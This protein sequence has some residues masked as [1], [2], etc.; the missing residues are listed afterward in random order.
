MASAGSYGLSG[1]SGP[2][3]YWLKVAG[4]NC[5]GPSAPAEFAPLCTPGRSD[6]P[7]SVS[8]SPIPASTDQ[9]RPGQVWA[10]SMY[11]I[12]YCGGMPAMAMPVAAPSRPVR[13]AVAAGGAG[14]AVTSRMSSNGSATAAAPAAVTVLITAGS[15]T[16]TG[17]R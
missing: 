13:A 8:T 1:W 5:I 7:W 17:R 2:V 10:A 11:H 3:A 15:L 16:R 9:G 6:L 14:L 12:R 4:S